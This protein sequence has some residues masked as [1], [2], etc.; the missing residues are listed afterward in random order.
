MIYAHAAQ[1]K[2]TE[3]L[4][5]DARLAMLRHQVQPH[6][7]FNAPNSVSGLSRLGEGC[8]GRGDAHEPREFL[9]IFVDLGAQRTDDP[10]RGDRVSG[11]Y[12]AVEQARFPDRL[13]IVYDLDPLAGGAL[14]PSLIVQPLVENAII[15]GL[16]MSSETTT[17]VIG[18]RVR[19]HAFISGPS[20]TPESRKRRARRGLASA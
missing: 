7:L 13:A 4:R 2:I 20:T 3:G 17:L 8:G 14:V 6:F 11:L 12:L 16:S 19:E 9:S 10:G 15:H 18:S 1:Q 5:T